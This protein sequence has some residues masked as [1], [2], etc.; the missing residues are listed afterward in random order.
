M[1]AK[2]EIHWPTKATHARQLVDGVSV[3]VRR[4]NFDTLIPGKSFDFGIWKD[5]QFALVPKEAAPSPVAA[6]VVLTAAG[7]APVASLP[8]ARPAG[9]PVLTWGGRRAFIAEHVFDGVLT[10]REIA[11]LVV[12]QW[13]D[14]PAAKA[15]AH[16]R[17]TAGHL[18][19]AGYNVTYR[20]EG[21]APVV[22]FP[23]A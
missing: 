8:V 3:V 7:I 10:A 2:S 22:N 13:P 21:G 14:V 17:A 23:A 5:R 1:S 9:R 6:P 15:L 16:A 11:A 19:V 18:K 12:A 20:K 4:D